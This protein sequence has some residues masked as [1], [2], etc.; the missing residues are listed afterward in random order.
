MQVKNVLDMAFLDNMI[1][2]DQGHKFLSLPSYWET[3]SKKRDLMAMI[4][5]LGKPTIFLTL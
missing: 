3:R 4:R 2:L 1:K 5:Q